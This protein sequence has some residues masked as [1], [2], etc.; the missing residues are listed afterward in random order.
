MARNNFVLPFFKWMFRSDERRQLEKAVS[1]KI[2]HISRTSKETLH[3]L[4]KKIRTYTDLLKTN[5]LKDENIARKLDYGLIRYL[6][7]ILGLP[8]FIV[9][10]IANL[11]PY[12]VPRLICN[13]Q[14]KDLR[15]YSSVYIGIGTILYLIYFPVTLI[16]MGVFAGWTGFFLGLLIPLL[17][18]LVL[19]YQEVFKERYHTLRFSITKLKNRALIKELHSLREDI[20]KDLENIQ[21]LI[22][23]N[24]T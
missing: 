17:G 21:I 8:L 7:V 14:I 23:S 3:L 18:Y 5:R 16:L 13:T 2:N 6:A 10:Y 12:V 22:P 24:Q 4:E 9:G 1:E 15:F 20:F 19:F 11:I